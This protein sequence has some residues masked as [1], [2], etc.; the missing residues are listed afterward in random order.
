MAPGSRQPK[1]DIYEAVILLDGYLEVLQANQPKA[2]IV[3]RVSADLRRMATNR[4]IK[5]DDIYRNKNGISY[6]IQSMD[7]AYKGKK[8]YVPATRLFEKAVEMY[9][10]GT[11]RYLEILEEAKN[12]VAAKQNNK[13]AF[14]AW[15]ASVLSTQRCKWVEENILKVEQLAV[16]AKLIFGSI[17][18]VTDMAT[19][20]AIYRAAGKNKI[21]QIKNRKLIKNINDDFKAYMEYCSQTPEQ[22]EQA[23][24]TE[25]PAVE[26]PAEPVSIVTASTEPDNGPLVVDFGSEESM[27]FTKPRSITFLGAELLRPSTWKDVYVSTVSALY[28]N[29]PD[30]FG[31]LSSF[32]SSTSLEFGKTDD[33]S[34]MTAPKEISEELCVETNFSAT[35]FIKRIKIL[36]SICGVAYD[37]LKIVYERRF[38]AA[39]SKNASP[40]STPASSACEV[41]FYSYLQNTAKLADG[42]CSSYVSSIRSA[43]RYAADNGYASRALFSE[44]NETTVATAVELYGD[45][46]F[47]RYNEQQHNRFSAAIN[48]LLESIG[49]EIPEKIVASHSG[50]NGQSTAPAEVNSEI[51][52]VLK[53]HYEYGFKYDSIRELMRFRQFAD[54]MGITLP[55]EDEIFKASILSS[56][57]V[58]DDKVYCKSDDMPQELQRI[59]DDVLSSGT[60]IIYYESLFEREQE[61]MESHVITSSDMLKEYLQKNI[62]GC[63]FSKKFMVK[64]SRRS[65]KEAVTDELKRVWGSRPLESVYN[66]HDRLPYIPLGNIWRV[67]SGNDLFV[68]AAEGE[69]LF[70]DRFRITEDEESD[71][72]DFV[73][74]ACEENGFASLSDVPLGGIE[75][76][77]Y[78][79]TQLAIYNAIYKKVLSGKYH[80]NGKILTKEK[81]KLDAVML[82]KQYIKDKD[83][84]TFDDVA[85]KVVELTGGTNRQYA[86]QALYDDMVRVDR[87]RFV[88]NRLV[89]FSVDE[90]DAV[91]SG[92]ITDNFRA[93]RDVTTFAMFP[94]CGQSWNHYLLESFCYKYSRKYSLHVIHF[95]D[96]NAGIIAEKD[97]NRKYNEMLAIA[98]ARTDVEL[99][100][101][102]IGQ[103]LFSTGY[104]AKIKYTKLSEIAQRAS[105]LRKER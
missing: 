1:W 52:S 34:R 96:K 102:V 74:G 85:D 40:A 103:Y 41:A 80:L 23:D 98:L 70:I 47:I 89:N 75:E 33:A 35:D 42:T 7:S 66:L 58:I 83:E 28:E 16:A 64:G 14:L 79:L 39:V 6:Q 27:A 9:R 51:V 38:G 94:L 8:V 54:A 63:S 73:D 71:I 60:G 49:A 5:I 65:E 18:D 11:E 29:H 88:A 24:E 91:L 57:V 46:D 45:S 12:M 30:V 93:I 20:E 37:D 43:E 76:E 21:F 101:E 105:E 81:S 36:L 72:F 100:P 56:G 22:V 13:D 87:N 50:D 95:N 84:C 55:E 97:F 48:K 53:Q 77:N 10:T 104:M 2:Q 44:D 99:S 86:F 62:N 61:W 90:I 67:I 59:V 78:E 68:L 19:L 92:V 32:P 69:Y 31:S 3:R 4:G 15:A 25:P 82:L 26:T 17:F